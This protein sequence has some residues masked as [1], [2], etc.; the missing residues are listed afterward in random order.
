[1]LAP[2][3]R[4]HE[5]GTIFRTGLK[6]WKKTCWN[7]RPIQ[8]I[9]QIDKYLQHHH[10]APV[11]KSYLAPYPHVVV[12]VVAAAAAAPATGQVVQAA[13]SHVVGAAAAVV[14]EVAGAHDDAGGHGLAGPQGHA[15]A[16]VRVTAV[17][18]NKMWEMTCCLKLE[19]VKHGKQC[20]PQRGFPWKLI[21]RKNIRFNFGG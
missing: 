14:R 13:L 1:M 12:A 7:F 20:F 8:T 2:V 15:A 6:T 9:S 21:G 19:N 11:T 3:K 4:N 17:A 10:L 18:G 5:S 16:K